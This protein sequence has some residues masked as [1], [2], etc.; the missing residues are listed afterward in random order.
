MQPPRS[1]K[2]NILQTATRFFSEKGF[3]DTSM[4]EIAKV[5]GVADGTIFYHFKTKGEL[6][7]AVLK[8]FK[9]GIINELET[10]QDTTV[11]STGLDM[12]EGTVSFYF[13]LAERMEERFLLLHRHYP[14]KLAM[15]NLDCRKHLEEIY[16]CFIDLFDRAIL[17]GQKDGSIRELHSKKQA[18]LLF[19]LVDGLVRLKTY[20]LYRAE[21]LY[22][23]LIDS[24]RCMLTSR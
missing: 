13:S 2:E 6:F 5:T 20:N 16:T 9:E 17:Q 14:Y 11:F 1:R 15:D 19:T 7:L 24:C 12:V 3:R 8:N 10:F 4:S 21:P 22:N 18:L 23:D